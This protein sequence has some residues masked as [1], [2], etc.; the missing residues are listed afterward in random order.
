[1]RAR[2]V[3]RVT[4]AA[5]ALDRRDGVR[6]I[7]EAEGVVMAAPVDPV[8]RIRSLA[9]VPLVA[10]ASGNAPARR[11]LLL[12]IED[13]DGFVGWGEVRC[14]GPGRPL[15]HRAAL[16][17]EVFAIALRARPYHEPLDVW[18]DLMRHAAP[19]LR[20]A[21]E[22]GPFGQ[23]MAGIDIALWDLWS[24]REAM[25][26]WRLLSAQG[27]GRAA[28]HAG[29]LPEHEPEAHVGALAER[30]IGCV[31]VAMGADAT[32]DRLRLEAVCAALEALS[33]EPGQLVVDARG[34]WTPPVAASK[35]TAL[36]GI[37]PAWV[38][39]PIPSESPVADWQRLAAGSAIPLAAGRVVHEE[40]A[41]AA[42]L[43]NPAV[44]ILQLDLSRWSGITGLLPVLRRAGG[45]GRRVVLS[46]AG[47][48]VAERAALHL[49]AG[50]GV[51]GSVE[52]DMVENALPAQ[53]G[54]APPEVTDGTVWLGED[55]G[56]GL[57]AGW[58]GPAAESA[59]R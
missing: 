26:V 6:F 43:T 48:P 58:D 16:L 22:P 15:E 9:P 50:T 53:A 45:L 57:T 27:T 17:R 35:L 44:P 29:P 56:L 2:A 54:L 36:A 39:E 7:P 23:C 40:A 8:F 13:E 38:A 47:G 49:L 30:G 41:A 21:G 12:R 25:P 33:G 14:D 20:E 55:S 5:F 10:P 51:A 42:V 52:L 31:T 37:T 4:A 28:V 32:R 18:P 46:T 19:L 3:A 59:V 24:R 34:L 11:V 1:M